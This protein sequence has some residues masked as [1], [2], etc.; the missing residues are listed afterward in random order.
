MGRRWLLG[1]ALVAIVAAAA[2]VAHAQRF[3]REGS[4]APRYAPSEMPD[5]T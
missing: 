5:A 2:G 3:F 1:G 4:Y